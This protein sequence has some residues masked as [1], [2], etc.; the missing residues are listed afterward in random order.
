MIELFENKVV[1]KNLETPLGIMIACATDKGL[2]MLEFSDRRALLTEYKEIEKYFKTSIKDGTNEI[3]ENIEIELK[4]YFSGELKD[5]SVPLDAPGSEFQKRV[6]NQLLKIPYGE[7]RS[8]KAQSI[9]INSPDSVRAVANANGKNRISIVI[10]CHRV[11]G[12]DGS[13]TG[14]GG[15]LHRKQWLLNHES[16]NLKMF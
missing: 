4:K 5:F 13:L 9:A 8:Y 14:Y 12:E 1:R 16:N 11:I 15:G 6:W 3:I 10:P 2:C 7:T